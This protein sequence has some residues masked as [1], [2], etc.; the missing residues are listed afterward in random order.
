MKKKT[1]KGSSKGIAKPKEFVLKSNL[2]NCGVSYKAGD[3]VPSDLFSEAKIKYLKSL[4]V[5]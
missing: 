3:K 2:T 4:D 1:G 5:I